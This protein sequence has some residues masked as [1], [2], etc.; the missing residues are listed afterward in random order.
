MNLLHFSW[1]EL[2]FGFHSLCHPEWSRVLGGAK[3]LFTPLAYRGAQL[4]H[5]P[6]EGCVDSAIL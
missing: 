5:P 2:Q 6:A 3:D 1:G 4:H